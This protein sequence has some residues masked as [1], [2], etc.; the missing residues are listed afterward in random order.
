[1]FPFPPVTKWHEFG[2]EKSNLV[3]LHEFFIIT[4]INKLITNVLIP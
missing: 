2:F 3:K 1:M 4:W